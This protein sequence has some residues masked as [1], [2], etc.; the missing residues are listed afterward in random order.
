VRRVLAVVLL[1]LAG[2]LLTVELLALLD[3]VGTK[4]ADDA[5]PFG[6]P[7]QPWWAHALW[8]AVIAVLVGVGVRLGRFGRPDRDHAT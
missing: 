4:L 8:F 5:D 7:F 2:M 6:H 3:P 1:V